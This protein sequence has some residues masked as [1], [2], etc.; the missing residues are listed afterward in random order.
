MNEDFL[1]HLSG[2]DPISSHISHYINP[3]MSANPI[4]CCQYGEATILFLK[5]SECPKSTTEIFK[6]NLITYMKIHEW[7]KP[8]SAIAYNTI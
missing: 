8:F 7:L 5:K 1:K 4:P 2:G 6:F 3:F